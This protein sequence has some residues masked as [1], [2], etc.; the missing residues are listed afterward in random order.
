MPVLF[1]VFLYMGAASLKG[2]QFFDRLLI[3]LM[4]VK[5]QPDFMFLRQVKTLIVSKRDED[6]LFSTVLGTNQTSAFIYTDS[7]GL[8]SNPLV[9]QVIFFNVHLISPHV[10]HHDCH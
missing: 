5:Y 8:L 2:L 1:G 7:T 3:M 4:P 9:N 6:I 10:G